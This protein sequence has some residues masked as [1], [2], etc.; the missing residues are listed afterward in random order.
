[1]R[2]AYL[3]NRHIEFRPKDQLL[4]N[5]TN[6]Q[7][8]VQLSIPATRCLLLLIKCRGLAEQS[9]FF[10]YVWGENAKSATPNNLYQNIS[11]LRKALKGLSANNS[12]WIITVP[13]KGFTLDSSLVIEELPTT[14]SST[15]QP[16]DASPSMKDNV[17][18]CA[19]FIKRTRYHAVTS[20]MIFCSIILT[21]ISG[22]TMVDHAMF[23]HP[24]L[25]DDFYLYKQAEGCQIY[26]NKDTRDPSSHM[27]VMSFI[28]QNCKEEP[29][30][31][32]TTYPILHSA[33][34]LACNRPI[35]RKRL[36]CVSRFVRGFKTS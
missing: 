1:M 30:L 12:N 28:N 13:R 18:K 4:L 31:Y 23:S 34:V 7:S 17:Q 27:E 29:Y 16:P 11:L 35:N 32:I 21:F 6:P 10:G 9:E 25:E 14:D 20:F 2:E 8:L 3:I 19:T 15:I 5:R 36:S 22:L 24:S 33:T 26:I